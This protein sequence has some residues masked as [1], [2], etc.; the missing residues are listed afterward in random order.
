VERLLRDV[1]RIPRVHRRRPRDK[2]AV[3]IIICVKLN[4]DESFYSNDEVY[5]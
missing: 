3:I 4:E 2:K 1:G 5:L